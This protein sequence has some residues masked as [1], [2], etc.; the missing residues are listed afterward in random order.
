MCALA[1]IAGERNSMLT[2]LVAR[3]LVGARARLRGRLAIVAGA[4]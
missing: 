4:F 2:F 3:G 1:S